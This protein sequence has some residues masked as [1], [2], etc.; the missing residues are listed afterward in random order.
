MDY[1]KLAQSI[2]ESNAAYHWHHSLTDDY[3]AEAYCHG[4]L[5]DAYSSY[6]HTNNYRPI[7]ETLVALCV[8]LCADVTLSGSK[9]DIS[10][11]LSKLLTM[12]KPKNFRYM[13]IGIH[14]AIS[15]FYRS[16]TAEVRSLMALYVFEAAEMYCEA[17]K[18]NFDKMVQDRLRDLEGEVL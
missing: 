17:H 6:L 4:E 9:G 3:L 10:E 11:R 1:N 18:I 15:L 12:R 13:P 14:D 8:S 2:E 7:A 16:E 5:N